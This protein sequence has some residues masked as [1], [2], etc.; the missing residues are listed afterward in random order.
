MQLANG[1][2]PPLPEVS[3]SAVHRVRQIQ[4][5]LLHP[6]LCALQFIYESTSLVNGI[7]AVRGIARMNMHWI[8]RD[9][10]GE[11]LDKLV[12]ARQCGATLREAA[13]TAGVHVATVCRWMKADQDFRDEMREAHDE[14]REWLTDFLTPERRRVRWRTDCP[15]CRAKVVVRCAKGKAWFWRCGRWPNCSW[16]SW[17]PRHPR[18]CQ[19]CRA[20]RYWSHSRKS[21]ACSECGLRTR[22][23]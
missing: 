7:E 14:Y 17:R 21:I 22:A 18:D 2:G 8:S 1:L 19:R 15:A 6:A 3:G 23:P 12:Q 5:Q 10:K 4:R 20:P 11:A 9:P 13:A 16:A